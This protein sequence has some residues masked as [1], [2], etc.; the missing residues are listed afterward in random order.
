VLGTSLRRWAEGLE[1]SAA[2]DAVVEPLERLAAM[3]LP[4][5]VKGFLKGKWLGHAFHPL[6]TDFPLGAWI[7]ASLLDL[8]GGDETRK[9]AENLV[10]FGLL[11]ALPTAAAGLAEWS[12]ADHE[13][14]RVGAVHASM[15]SFVI[16]L[17]ASSL[18]ARKRDRHSAAVALAVAGGVTAT[19]SGYLGGHLSL[20][21]GI[22]VE[23]VTGNQTH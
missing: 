15:N 13:A 18:A 10:A 7:S 12:D 1:S 14:K 5:Q 11:A 20:V 16:A 21:K 3:L 2:L 23:P 19:V 17:Y 9:A 6:L 22:G 8:F 4:P